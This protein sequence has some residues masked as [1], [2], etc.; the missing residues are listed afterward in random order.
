VRTYHEEWREYCTHIGRGER[1]R[2]SSTSRRTES[3]FLLWLPLSFFCEI[4]DMVPSDL[5][6]ERECVCGCGCGCG[7]DCVAF[8]S[9]SLSKQGLGFSGGNYL[10]VSFLCDHSAQTQCVDRTRIGTGQPPSRILLP[11]FTIVF[12]WVFFLTTKDSP[13]PTAATHSHN[14]NDG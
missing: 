7:E 1:T 6:A 4:A 13:R 11:P 2:R 10:Q 5:S 12:F 3:R 9:Y 14:N 8:Y